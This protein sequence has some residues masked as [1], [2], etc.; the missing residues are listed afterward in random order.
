MLVML[1]VSVFFLSQYHYTL[2]DAKLGKVEAE[3]RL[4]LAALSE[5][6]LSKS[7]D[8]KILVKT[9][10]TQ[11]PQRIIVFGTDKRVMADSY[12]LNPEQPSTARLA[13]K[14]LNSIR[15]LRI[16]TLGVLD[17]LFH[18]KK[19][20]TYKHPNSNQ[21]EDFPFVLNALN[22]ENRVSV[23]HNEQE[24]I[25]LSTTLTLTDKNTGDTGAILL[26]HKGHDLEVELDTAW[27]TMLR[28]FCIAFVFVVLL[29]IYFTGVITRPLKK[30]ARAAEG[31]RKGKLSY[32]DIPDFTDRNDEIGELAVSLQQ[33]TKALSDRIGAI[34][35]FAGDVAHELKNPL[36]SLRSAVETLSVVKKKADREKLLAII[37]HDINRLN[38]LIND[39]SH[40][41][42][43]DA[44]LSRDQSV[45]VDVVAL[46]QDLLGRYTP[47]LKRDNTPENMVVIGDITVAL[48][49]PAR[50]VMA[51]GDAGRL[52]QVLENLM[53]N[54]LSFAPPG[55]RIDLRI[56]PEQTHVKIM[57]DD[58]GPGI[59]DSDLSSIF[60]RF[61][62]SRPDH[63]AYGM[64]SGL[65]LSICT[66]IV[67]AFGGEIYAENLKKN[68]TPSGARFTVV[69]RRV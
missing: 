54:A 61:Y 55:S 30:L 4:I 40:V 63:E 32:R 59:P 35:S 46:A 51:W 33:M 2:V 1:I 31:V 16:F 12:I 42:K 9:L 52:E 15:I 48:H 38:R 21:A 14:E 3:A 67:K 66:Q 26:I 5:I 22:G 47:P 53:S 24:E 23:W 68:G 18:Q 50:T 6:D 62:S 45:P 10:S 41:S 37:H 64:H 25:V 8:I 17:A 29:S 69:L 7:D 56:V 36:T 11:T 39:I 44:A 43:L 57:L 65:G 58:Q 13:K 20:P 60:E 19:F 34:E 49:K 28:V 27:L